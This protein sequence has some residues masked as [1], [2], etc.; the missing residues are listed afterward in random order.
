MTDEGSVQAAIARAKESRR[1]TYLIKEQ[2][3]ATN[4]AQLL[5]AIRRIPCRIRLCIADC[6]ILAEAADL[7]CR[8][9]AEKVDIDCLILSK[10]TIQNQT[11][12]CT[13]IG[14]IGSLSTLSL[15]GCRLSESAIEALCAGFCELKHL[16]TLELASDQLGPGAFTSVCR[17]LILNKELT[18][19]SWEGNQL[20]DIPAFGDFVRSTESLRFLNFTVIQLSDMWMAAL[21]EL[22]DASWQ[23]A[24]L[25]VSSGNAQLMDRIVRNRERYRTSQAHPGF[26]LMRYAQPRS[27]SFDPFED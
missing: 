1:N 17:A 14:H 6:L 19:F 3:N 2:L 15:S 5:D 23:I 20:G 13:G 21:S 24:D 8:F 27:D 4:T 9:F 25:K 16:R 18:T 26:R 7:L 22:L 11:E 12:F 10:V